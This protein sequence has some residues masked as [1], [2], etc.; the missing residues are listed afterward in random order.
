MINI[1]ETIKNLNSR[2][3]DTSYFENGKEAGWSTPTLPLSQNLYIPLKGVKKVVGI[4]V[5]RPKNPN[6]LLTL[7]EKNF[8][9]VVGQ[10]LANYIVRSSSIR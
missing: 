7:E 5:Y 10:E 4:I 2:G 3:F 1:E 8:L 6:R 9:Y